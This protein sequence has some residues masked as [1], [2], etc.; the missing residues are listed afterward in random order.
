MFFKKDNLP[1]GGEEILE[2]EI[3]YDEETEKELKKIYEKDGKMPDFKNFEIKRERKIKTFLIGMVV[4]F[5]LLAVS[6]W[7]GFFILKPYERFGGKSVKFEIKGPEV[8]VSGAE[9][10]LEISYTNKE[11]VPLGEADITLF[12]TP[13]FILKESNPPQGENGVWNLGAIEKG[14]SGKIEL[15]GI[16]VGEK[17][18]EFVL[19][20]AL[21]YRPANFN[22]EF[23]KVANYSAL[24]KSIILD[25][26]A[27]GAT[28]AEPG[29]EIEFIVKYKN[30]ST[31]RVEKIA[32][33]P[34]FS[35]KFNFVFAEPVPDKKGRWFFDELKPEEEGE[36]KIKGV[37]SSE[38]SGDIAE[39]FQIG[40]MISEDKF[41]LQK[42]SVVPVRISRSDLILNLVSDR[43][44][45]V[46]FGEALQ[47]SINYKNNIA[48]DLSDVSIKAIF[49]S[50][51]EN[52]T[53]SP[54]MWSSLIDENRG[55]KIPFE[56]IWD[57]TNIPALAK[58]T[59]GSEGTINFW[60]NLI[61]EPFS[62]LEG[63]YKISVLSE[64]KI[65]KIGGDPA[66]KPVQS[67]KITIFLNS[68]A[69]IIAKGRYFNDDNI[70]VGSGPVPP[71]VGEKT[72]YKIF[73][74]IENT[75]H[76]LNNIVVSGILPAG[77]NWENVSFAERG[78]IFYDASS[79]K[80][81]WR[82]DNLP[83]GINK[84]EVNFSVSITPEMSDI[85]KNLIILQMTTFE[86]QDEET[87]G[88]IV[89]TEPAIT[90]ELL[91][92]PEAQGRGTVR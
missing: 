1:S 72:T 25:I 61:D 86:A 49:E 68:D 24:V 42:E 29:K 43:R 79:R 90:T 27:T 65:G 80:I 54:L 3:G 32:V 83:K 39:K 30:L 9:T 8:V 70:A 35:E 88:A 17:D 91:D 84:A 31:E 38:A 44:G 15:K 13:G 77:V 55:K 6:A 87:K 69:S 60:I 57:K 53:R 48:E 85:G 37:Y 5:A 58:L 52:G 26:E 45:S 28:D 14:E 22:S 74:T 40:F 10:I 89:L 71:K 16:I 2:E 18:S 47:F 82:M 11:D 51:P 19:T 59:S 75:L 21:N 63:E 41:I 73:W 7:A 33:N 46:N 56:I 76:A 4:F 81:S 34:V 36:I 50:D 23:E 20:G 64:A 62:D 12:T 92:D 67:E 66:N 78:N